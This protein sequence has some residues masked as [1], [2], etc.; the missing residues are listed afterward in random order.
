[1][2]TNKDFE[3]TQSTENKL[4]RE[5][6][7]DMYLES[8]STQPERDTWL[9]DSGASSHMTPHRNWFCEYKELKGGDVLLGD[10]SPTKIVG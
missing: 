1:M 6:K 9:V 10:D 2:G 4:K 5:E 7:G 8:M 3:E